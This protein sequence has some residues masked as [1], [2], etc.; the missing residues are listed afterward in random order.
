MAASYNPD[1]VPEEGNYTAAPTKADPQNIEAEKIVL[2]A[3]LLRQDA[4]NE[5][6]VKLS[7][8]DFYRSSHQIIFQTM[9]DMATRQIPVDHISLADQLKAA[10]QLDA[11]WGRSR[12]AV[13][14]MALPQVLLI[15][16]GDLT[17]GG[18]DEVLFRQAEV[19]LP[20]PDQGAVAGLAGGIDGQG[21]HRV[22]Q[23]EKLRHHR[24]GNKDLP[25]PPD[26]APKGDVSVAVPDEIA[27]EVKHQR[28]VVARIENTEV[29]M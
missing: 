19:G 24:R 5:V 29:G 22:L 13:R 3:C 10:G 17:E 15:P 28:A 1:Y 7:A 9:F 20:E 2:A 26:G 25:T 18:V 14:R 27:A 16:H 11:G 12:A 21:G 8:S 6:A 4:I 23:L